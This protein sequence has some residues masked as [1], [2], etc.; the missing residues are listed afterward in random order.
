MTHKGF[1]VLAVASVLVAL[2]AG[3]LAWAT[4]DDV[5]EPPAAKVEVM[6]LLLRP[7]QRTLG[8]YMMGSSIDD[9]V[10]HADSVVVVR[11]TEAGPI[12]NG[13]RAGGSMQA[14]PDPNYYSIAQMF[15]GHV[16]QWLKGSGPSDI[17]FDQSQGSVPEGLPKTKAAIEAARQDSGALKAVQVGDRLVLF[18]TAPD[19]VPELG[20][21]T[22]YPRA[23]RMPREFV[24]A[25]D[26]Y[27]AVAGDLS[28]TVRRD[29]EAVFPKQPETA[30]IDEIEKTVA[31]TKK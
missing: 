2:V 20:D 24:L 27:A 3:V 23:M 31:A 5:G 7:G 25:S 12:F 8:T 17:W 1:R 6:R 28:P 9:L 26:G 14:P 21:L 16:E 4:T 29:V 19:T 10:Q 13:R 11:V 18:L 22:W 30:L 15:K